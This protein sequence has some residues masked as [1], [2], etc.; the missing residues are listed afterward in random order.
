ML[1]CRRSTRLAPA[2]GSCSSS[3]SCCGSLLTRYVGGGAPQEPPGVECLGAPA[4]PCPLSPVTGAGEGPGSPEAARGA[5]PRATQEAAADPGQAGLRG[6]PCP[7]ASWPGQ[8]AQPAASYQELLA[9]PE[10][11][12]AI[13]AR[14]HEG[15]GFAGEPKGSQSGAARVLGPARTCRQRGRVG[16]DAPCSPPPPAALPLPGRAPR[17]GC[18]LHRQWGPAP[19][20]C[21]GARAAAAA[22][23]S[24]PW[25]GTPSRRRRAPLGPQEGGIHLG[26]EGSAPFLT[27][28]P[29]FLW[30]PGLPGLGQ[31]R[32]APCGLTPREDSAQHQLTTQ[33]YLLSSEAGTQSLGSG[34]QNPGMTFS[35]SSV[36]L[37]CRKGCSG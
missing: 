17:R 13:L 27:P 31:G 37:D 14:Q 9:V 2:T 36:S 23:W 5:Q 33:L 30:A 18:T 12:A 6:C 28:P 24:Q 7:A 32:P 3:S 21:P 11:A 8:Q 4:A 16:A 1:A 34:K 20:L 19:P 35:R 26:E 22:A 29:A 10:P 25:G 15:E